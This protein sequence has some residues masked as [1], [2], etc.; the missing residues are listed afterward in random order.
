MNKVIIISIA[1]LFFSCQENYTPKPRGF[2][3]ISFPEK[4]F[5]Q[6]TGNCPFTFQFPTYSKID[7]LEKRCFFNLQFPD[8]KATLHV[9]Y[10][11]VSENLYEHTEESRT[12]AYKHSIKANAISEQPFID[13]KNSVFGLVYDYEGTTAT[14]LQFYLTDS[15]NHFFRGALYFN[16]EVNDSLI[17]ITNFLQEDIK[18]LIESFRWKEKLAQQKTVIPKLPQADVP[19][20]RILEPQKAK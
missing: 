18:Y 10:F 9:S 4:E 8:F 17:P 3:K 13:Q 15:T 2:F 14:A 5:Q 7:T 11:P 12:L 16:T 19:Q 20:Q 6:Y 1:I